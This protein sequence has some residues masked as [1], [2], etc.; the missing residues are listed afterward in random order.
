MCWETFEIESDADE[1][2]HLP[3]ASLS[4]FAL[5]PRSFL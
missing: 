1:A 4:N 2:I 3:V 5:D